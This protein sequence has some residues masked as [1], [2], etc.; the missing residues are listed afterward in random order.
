MD[1]Q[2]N[3]IQVCL[4]GKNSEEVDLKQ[5]E[6]VCLCLEPIHYQILFIIISFC[7]QYITSILLSYL[8][9]LT[10]QN[11][12]AFESWHKFGYHCSDRSAQCFAKGLIRQLSSKDSE[13]T[14]SSIYE[15]EKWL[16]VNPTFLIIWRSV[17]SFLYGYSGNGKVNKLGNRSNSQI[18]P[19]QE[20]NSPI[21]NES[22]KK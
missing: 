13:E 14:A 21:Y 12:P 15:L 16:Q 11:S 6:T 22:V 7:V 5:L 1:E 4:G 9:I 19:M 2:V 17:F 10:S 20:G 8:H 3:F 18:L